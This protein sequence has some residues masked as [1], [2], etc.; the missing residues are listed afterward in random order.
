MR[1]KF[2]KAGD[3]GAVLNRAILSKNNPMADVLFGVDNTFLSRAIDAD[4]FEPYSSPLLEKIP[5]SFK[6]DKKNRLLPV[7]FGDVC[8]NY[9]AQWFADRKVPPP[10]G[11]IDLTKPA[12]SG[13]TVVENPAT[14]SPGLAFLLATISRFGESGYIDFWK[15][16]NKNGAL[17]TNGWNEA[18]WGNFTASSK[19]DR[20]IV[21]SYSS[22][23]AAEVHFSGKKM[24]KAPTDSI[25]GPGECFR[26]IE[27]AGIFRG[28]KN[29]EKAKKFIDFML[30]TA[31]QEDIP[32]SMFV[33]PV[34]SG[35]R[36]PEVFAKHAK[37]AEKPAFISYDKI[38]ARRMDWIE[39]WTNEML[40]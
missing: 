40:R 25:A 8:L 32:L 14:S 36:L 18:Y 37:T 4:M 9:D 39:A 38:A 7:D 26:Q 11:M 24:K 12:Y 33:F 29:M 6:L 22:S 27:F 31:F 23:P 34:N 2:L 35:A 10:S 3:A 16:L 15:K 21:V 20:P 13:L 17:V 28:S 19:G 1:L 5:E 30:D